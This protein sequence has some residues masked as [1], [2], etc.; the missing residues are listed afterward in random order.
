MPDTFDQRFAAHFTT[1]SPRLREAGAYIAA[2]PVD[3][4]SRGLRAIAAE[5]QMAPATFTRLAHALGFADFEALRDAI[6]AQIALKVRRFAAR[7]GALQHEEGGD[8]S[9]LTRYRDACTANLA[10]LTD[11]VDPAQLEALVSRLGT[12]RRVLLVGALGSFGVATYAAY[13]GRFLGAGWEMAGQGGSSLA[14][15]LAGLGPQDVLLVITKPPSARNSIRA[16]EAAAK[17]GAHVA[18]ITDSRACPAMPH[19]STA[20]ILPDDG[21]S[22]FSS[23]VATVFLLETVMG[24][25]AKQAGPSV[26][27]RIAQIEA[28]NRLL[29]EVVD[30]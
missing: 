2:N 11:A 5:S 22:F 9:F 26:T 15:S 24:M 17:S 7:A 1:L 12:A 27:E 14:S 16:A 6:R 8:E 25:V 10:A 29:G 21:P 28:Q 13:M 23:Y 4:A 3:T 30:S 20:F 19:A 18:L